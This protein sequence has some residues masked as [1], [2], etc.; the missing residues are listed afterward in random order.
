MKGTTPM[1]ALLILAAALVGY[2]LLAL[3]SPVTGCRRCRGFGARGR[4]RRPCHRCGGTGTRFRPGAP[5]I[6]RAL[7]GWRRHRASGTLTL[8]PLR[9][10][11]HR[12]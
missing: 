9:P 6:Y 7:S 12:P 2:A 8:P 4:R 10:P 3:A 11:R 1:T 5:L